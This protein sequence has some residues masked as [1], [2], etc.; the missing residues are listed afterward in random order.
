V[1]AP[2]GRPA[3]PLFRLPPE[4][5]LDA[6]L[7]L[8]GRR[9]DVVHS[10]QRG[11]PAEDLVYRGTLVSAARGPF[12]QSHL[13]VVRIDTLDRGTYDLAVP[14]SQVREVRPETPP[15]EAP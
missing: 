4:D 5:R 11:S 15:T 13:L 10:P 8:V 2:A 14:L 12:H 3:T 1:S 9:V 7:P 6:V